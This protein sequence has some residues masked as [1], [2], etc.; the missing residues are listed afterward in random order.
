[1]IL[2]LTADSTSLREL[3]TLADWTIRPRL[4][5]TGGVAQVAV[6]GGEMKEYRILL[7]P[8]RMKYYGVGLDQV[9][10]ACRNMNRN[11]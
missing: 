10:E 1:M 7:S 8:E 11:V 4:L 6:I 2:G 5:S 3:R 9:L